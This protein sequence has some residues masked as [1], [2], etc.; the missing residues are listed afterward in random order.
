MDACRVEAYNDTSFNAWVRK[1]RAPALPESLKL[2]KKLM[3][4]GIKI[5]FLCGRSEDTREATACNLKRVGY[6]TWEKLILRYIF[7]L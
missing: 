3:S 5:I 1:S 6:H 2:Y 7:I 4:L